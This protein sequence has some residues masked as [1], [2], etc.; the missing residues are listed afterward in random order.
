M[1]EFY[2]TDK[3]VCDD[4]G[5]HCGECQR[6]V[7]FSPDILRGWMCRVFGEIVKIPNPHDFIRCQACLDAQKEWEAKQEEQ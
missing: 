6:Q 1:S 4:D 2:T 7:C 5:I 3:I